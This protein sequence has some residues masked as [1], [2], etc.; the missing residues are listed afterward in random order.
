MSVRDK[1]LLMTIACACVGP[2][3]YFFGVY[4]FHVMLPIAMWMVLTSTRL[5]IKSSPRIS[6]VCGAFALCNVVFDLLSAL[7]SDFPNASIRHA[8]F[9]FLGYVASGL[10]VIY[11]GSSWG[12]FQ[13]ALNCVLIVSGASLAIGLFEIATPFRWPFSK[14]S[15]YADFVGMSQ[16]SFDLKQFAYYPEVLNTTPTGLNW[17]PNNFALMIALAL[18]FVIYK[19]SKQFSAT[20]QLAC[21]TAISFSSARLTLI[22][23]AVT[24]MWNGL[25]DRRTRWWWSVAAIV[26]FAFISTQSLP[27]SIR[28]L[29]ELTPLG[30]DYKEEK[31]ASISYR[32]EL[33][34]H[35]LRLFRDHPVAGIGA[36]NF[37]P[38]A[39]AEFQNSMPVSDLHFYWLQFVVEKGLVGSIVA[40]MFVA[41][42]VSQ[43]VMRWRRGDANTRRI[44]RQFAYAFVILVIGGIGLSSMVYYLPMYVLIGLA[45]A[46]LNTGSPDEN[47]VAG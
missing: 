3:I 38:T 44:V 11:V 33:M 4:P 12:K 10:V 7:W 2:G 21:V 42:L 22:A 29:N 37:Q 15:S 18:P 17:N 27:K 19:V 5:S 40:S 26:F 20:I 14:L 41:I 46:F 9:E 6:R 32:K 35:A 43:F 28:Q 31:P 34:Q 36:G 24:A 23:V 30:Y 25:V 8:A 39:N 1:I 47:I 13:N 16:S 45:V